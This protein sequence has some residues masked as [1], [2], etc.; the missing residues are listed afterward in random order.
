MRETTDKLAVGVGEEPELPIETDSQSVTKVG[1]NEDSLLLPVTE[2]SRA[3][4]GEIWDTDD[5]KAVWKAAISRAKAIL[6]DAEA[7]IQDR[8][9]ALSLIEQLDEM[10]HGSAAR[11]QGAGGHVF[12]LKMLA[13]GGRIIDFRPVEFRQSFE[14]KSILKGEDTRTQSEKNSAAN[15][16]RKSVGQG[17]LEN[18]LKPMTRVR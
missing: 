11:Q 16:A 12:T 17:G 6:K 2:A 5:E 3:F 1:N 9:W 13:P 10:K 15:K 14:V 7:G 4:I 8:R 18:Y